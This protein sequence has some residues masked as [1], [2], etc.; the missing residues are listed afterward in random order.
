MKITLT[1][2]EILHAA[3]AGVTRNVT[4]LRDHRALEN[5]RADSGW[6]NHING[7]LGEYAVAKVLGRCWSPAVGVLDTDTGDLPGNWHVKSTTRRNGRLIVRR[8]DPME[9]TYALVVLD[10][11]HVE[12]VGWIPG[13]FAK[14]EE[15]W[16]EE[17][18]AR[19]IHQAAYFVPAANLHSFEAAVA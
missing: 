17:D 6:E 10:L 5:G 11:P 8:Q 7:A 4:A 9:M 13:E 14:L 1:S 16:E 3:M 18:R 12:V 15:F 19:G 2:H